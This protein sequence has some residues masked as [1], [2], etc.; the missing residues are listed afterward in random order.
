M[1]SLNAF[2]SAKLAALEAQSLRRQ[3]TE[4]RRDEAMWITRNGKRLLSFS[5]NDY[6]NLTQH[7]EIIAASVA[8][9][10]RWGVGSGGSRLVTGNHVLFDALETKLAALKG[11]QA[12]TVFGSG[13]LANVG[14]I[15]A[16]AG[17]SDLLLVDELA[18]ACIWAGATLSGARVL[19]F[20][21]NSLTHA[22][23]LL[24]AHRLE[25]QHALII[26]DHVFSMDGDLAPVAALQNLATQHDAWLMTDDA[27]GLGVVKSSSHD[28]PLQMGTLSKAIGAYGGYLCASRPVIDL[29]RN[30]ARSFVYSTGLPPGTIGAAIASLDLIAR[31]PDYAARPLALARRFTSALGLPEAQSPIVPLI[32]GPAAA[33]LA[34]SQK[35]AD[36]G[37]L[38]AAIRPPT[39]APGTSRLRFTFTAQHPVAEV[40]RLTALIR[41]QIR[42]LITL[43]AA[44]RT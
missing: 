11:T 19:R 8:A 32:L 7:P 40:D 20:A 29:I 30:R 12:A 31:E 38:V 3:L 9:T 44:T 6:L 17:K 18:H 28:V 2:A 43:D 33:A 23:E 39:V 21:H 25:H 36:A 42:P 1:A 26:T 24:A 27:H 13:Y 16:L 41:T 5:C 37:F 22:A 35:L 4:S 15:P 10:Q 14:I 34:A